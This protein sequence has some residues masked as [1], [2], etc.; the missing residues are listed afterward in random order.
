MIDRETVDRIFATADIVEVINDFVKLKK[1]GSNY[2]GL[3]PFSSE[4]TPSFFVSPGKGIFKDFS[5]GLGGNVVKFLMEVEKLSYPEAL[6]YLARKYNIE[7]H[8]KEA[9]AQEIQ[10]KNERESLIEVT[11]F[12]QKQ[13]TDW[14]WHRDEGRAIG[15]GYF[16]ERGF[17]DQVIEKFQ[18]GYSLETRDAFTMVA[19]EKG[20]KLE[21]LVKTGL[22]IDKNNFRFDRFAGRVIFPIHSLS[23]QVIGFGGRVLK[24]DDKT[25]KYLNSPESEIYHKSNVLYGLYFAKNEINKLDKCFLV[26]GYTDVISMHQAGIAN[27]VAS[28]GTA[29]TVEQIRLIKRFTK[30]ITVLYDGDPAGIKASLRGIDLILEEGMNVK[31][32]LLPDGEDPDSFARAN[33]S[34]RFIEF[35]EQNESDFIRF[36]TKL[37]L[38]DAQNDPVKRATLISDIVKSIAVIPESIVRSVYLRECSKLME[39]DEAILYEETFKIRS[40]KAGE[41]GKRHRP[42][43]PPS[44][45]SKK[46]PAH[47]QLNLGKDYKHEYELIRTLINFGNRELFPGYDDSPLIGKYIVD[48]IRADDLVFEHPV[49]DKIF[50]IVA[51]FVDQKMKIDTSFFIL[52]E[53]IEVSTVSAE[54][55]SEGYDDKMSKLWSK[56]DVQ[57]ETEE[58]KLKDIVP[59]LIISFKNRKVLQLIN[60]THSEIKHAQELNEMES[61]D[62]IIHKLQILNDLKRN[63]SKK[64]GDRI[65]LH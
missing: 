51:G 47:V 55:L 20:Y 21:Y 65:I 29:L 4:K 30:N 50:D 18:L 14:L 53:D 27:V 25:A 8:E 44:G 6:R 37:L 1:S 10:E 58:M 48:E 45:F 61:I 24:K 17:R 52:H 42:E 26:E 7:I 64:L 60:E 3:S 38:K 39:I 16:K 2:K 46:A 40:A 22:T 59:E 28:S 5:S 19:L 12:A 63:I 11:S 41:A 15:L 32:L 13:F 9:T 23:G 31:V 36:K 33:S 62:L 35:I 43:F 34:T 56:K 49:Y 57:L 54:M